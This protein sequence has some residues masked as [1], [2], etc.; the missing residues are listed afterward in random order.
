MVPLGLPADKWQFDSESM[1]FREL[2]IR[3]SYV[4][5][6]KEVESMF[7]VVAKHGISSHLTIVDFDKIPNLV[8]M[9]SHASMKGRLVVQITK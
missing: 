6:A 7:K 9:Y 8:E 1:V 3:G 4:A 5:S 2:T